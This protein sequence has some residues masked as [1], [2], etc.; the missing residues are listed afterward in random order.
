MIQNSQTAQQ[1][2]AE[3]FI[4]RLRNQTAPAHEALEKLPISQTIVCAD[5]RLEDYIGYLTLMA[6]ALHDSET[7]IFP[8]AEDLIPDLQ[9]RRKL[10]AILD[11]LTFHSVP[12]THFRPVFI[13]SEK[14]SAAFALGIL[15]VMEGSVL[16]GRVILK[17]LGKNLGLADDESGARYFYGYGAQ[18]GTRWKSF[19]EWLAGYEAAHDCGEEIIAGANHAFASIHRHFSQHS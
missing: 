3:L 19:M 15:Y 9:E 5:V 18:T 1:R 16:G 2:P 8:L 10:P 14:P 13:P 11:D 17:N 12:K 6:D 4:S 7:H